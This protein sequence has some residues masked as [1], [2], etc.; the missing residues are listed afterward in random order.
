MPARQRV[1]GALVLGAA[2]VGG[3]ILLMRGEIPFLHSVREAVVVFEDSTAGLDIGSPVNFRGIPVGAVERIDIAVDPTVN[4][5]F[6]SVRIEFSPRQVPGGADLP[7]VP[8]LVADG[9]RADMVLHSFVTGQSEI[10]LDFSPNTPARMHP[11][12]SSLPEIPVGQTTLQQLKGEL[13]APTM[14]KLKHDIRTA[15]ASIRQLATDLHRDVPPMMASIRQ[16]SARSHV[17]VVTIREALADAKTRAAVTLT[18][19]DRMLAT[20]G[21]EMDARRAELRHLIDEARLTLAQAHETMVGVQQLT[22]PQSPDQVHLA[23]MTR[24]VTAAAYGLR[25]F[26]N[27]VESN[28]QL[29]LMGRSQ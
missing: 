12:L 26:A 29:L 17:A 25:G 24:D 5:T 28:P 7:D 11:G 4:R 21:R 27:E 16:T 9:M 23:E 6:T 13:G 19:M 8:T 2:F 10:D 22:S 1:I 3:A 20:G 14:E 18:D 15:V